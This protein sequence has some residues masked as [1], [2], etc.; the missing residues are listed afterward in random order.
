MTHSGTPGI[1]EWASWY[2]RID[3]PTTLEAEHELAV[4]LGQLGLALDPKDVPGFPTLS[5][6]ES[7]PLPPHTEYGTFHA[8]WR[9]TGRGMGF[10]AEIQELPPVC[11]G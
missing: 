3:L 6:A 4:M 8:G 5:F 7:Q 1:K 10:S 2:S 11:T 9:E